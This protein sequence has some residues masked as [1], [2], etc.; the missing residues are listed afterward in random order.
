[1]SEGDTYQMLWDCAY[2]GADKL[3]GLTHRHCPSC[4][5]AQDEEKRYFPAEE[6]KVAVSDHVFVGADKDC[7]ACSSPMAA[8]AAHCGNCGSPMDAADQVTLKKDKP[9]RAR[10]SE[11][12]PRKKDS[13]AS[14]FILLGCALLMGM[15][16]V[17]VLVMILWQKDVAL[18]A[19]ARTWERSIVVETKRPTTESKW[20]D[21]LPRKA[22]S[23]ARTRKQR[24]TRKVADGQTCTTKRRDNG[25]G[26]FTEYEDCETKYREEP[27]YGEWCSYTV[28]R[29]KQARKLNE[30]GDGSQPPVWPAVTLRKTGDCIGCEREGTRKAR[31]VVT[32][33]NPEG[34]TYDCD[35][36]EPEWASIQIGSKWTS[37]TSVI[38][39]SLD[40][41]GL[42]RAP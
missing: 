1:M 21:D 5:S 25:D 38:G 41:K 27:I 12:P 4:G 40:C 33:L 31:Y 8:A 10:R 29:W 20:C 7:P 15:V 3:L 42:T 26:T 24:D 35:L 36:V 18:E 28:D 14:R 2:C 34:K 17:F 22:Y 13:K 32:F 19:T 37:Q 11:P 30:E 16:A 23:V 6:D 39:G 9:E